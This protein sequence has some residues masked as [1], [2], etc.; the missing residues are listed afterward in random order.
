MALAKKREAAIHSIDLQIGT[1]TFTVKPVPV[2]EV[3][4]ANARI[5]KKVQ[6]IFQKIKKAQRSSAVYASRIVLNA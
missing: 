4:R 3:A 5:Q 1:T 6:P 2:G